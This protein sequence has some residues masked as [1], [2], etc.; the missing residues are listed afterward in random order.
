MGGGQATPQGPLLPASWGETFAPPRTH[1]KAEA[2]LKRTQRALSTKRRASNRRRKLKQR[3]ARQHRKVSNQRKDF[4]HKLA[5]RLVNAYGTIVHEDLN[6]AGLRR[7]WLAKSFQDAGHA[8]FIAILSAKA[9]SAGRRVVAVKPHGTSQIC[10]SCGNTRKKELSERIHA[11]GCGC[12][13]DRDVAAAK[14]ILALGLDGAFGD[15]QR[16]AAPA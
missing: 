8:Q 15:G 9:A 16:V 14:V 7:S 10:P 12:V 5:R 3:L 2:K 1:R 11:C 13:L 4:H 6:L